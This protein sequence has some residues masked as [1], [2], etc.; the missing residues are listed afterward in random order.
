MSMSPMGGSGSCV[1][2][3]HLVAPRAQEVFLRAE[4]FFEDPG[5]QTFRFTVAD[6]REEPKRGVGRA[7]TKPRENGAPRATVR[8]GFDVRE[9]WLGLLARP[10]SPRPE[11][12]G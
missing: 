6:E 11:G 9:Q 12:W 3:P 10:S 2:P 8:V 4:L 5:E 7:A 1:P